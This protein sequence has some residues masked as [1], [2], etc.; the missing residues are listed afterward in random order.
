M[1]ITSMYLYGVPAS[2]FMYLPYH[3]AIKIKLTKGRE[4][5]KILYFE[6]YGFKRNTHLWHVGKAIK[7]NE[8]LIEVMEAESSITAEDDL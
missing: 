4:L 6:P 8:M 2:H 1:T 3:E 7:H 5:E